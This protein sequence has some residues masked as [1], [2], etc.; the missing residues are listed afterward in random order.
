MNEALLAQRVAHNIPAF[1]IAKTDRSIFC[2][3]REIKP[4]QLC[5]AGTNV[6]RLPQIKKK[7]D[8][9][10]LIISLASRRIPRARGSARHRQD[11]TVYSTA[12]SHPGALF[13]QDLGLFARFAARAVRLIMQLLGDD[14]EEL[15]LIFISIVI[16]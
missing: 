4:V 8:R 13:L 11:R 9:P 14:A 10:F 7:L 3:E 12:A 16:G 6:S 2:P 1:R 5:C 15:R